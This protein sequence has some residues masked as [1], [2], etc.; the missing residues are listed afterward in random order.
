MRLSRNL[1]I[2]TASSLILSLGQEMWFGFA[3]EFLRALG[4][5]VIAVGFFSSLQDLFEALYHY[6]G[7]WLTDR[8]GVRRSLIIANLAAGLGYFIYLISPHFAVKFE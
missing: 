5:G 7:G 4:A 6:P 8:Y 1:A 2:L 3:P